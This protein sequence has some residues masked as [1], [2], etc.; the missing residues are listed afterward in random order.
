MGYGRN[1][2]PKRLVSET[3]G[4]GDGQIVIGNQRRREAQGEWV[5]SLRFCGSR[6]AFDSARFCRS[7]ELVSVGISALKIS[8]SLFSG[9]SQIP[10]LSD[11]W[12]N[13]S[14]E[15]EEKRRKKTWKK[16]KFSI[17]W[18]FISMLTICR[19]WIFKERKFRNQFSIHATTC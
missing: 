17:Q 8:R 18:I 4:K 19:R 12:Q 6:F 13:N 11:T 1:P 15:V 16:R 10:A 3:W 2:D 5:A 9:Q 7:H 14:T